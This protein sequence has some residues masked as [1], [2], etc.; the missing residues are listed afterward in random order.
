M[1]LIR[2]NPNETLYPTGSKSIIS[3]I[4]N[5]APPQIILWRVPYEDFNDGSKVIVAENEEALF[6]ENGIVEESF[7][8]GEYTLN[9]NNYPFLSRIRNLVSGG[10]SAYNC[11]IIYIN[12]IHQLDNRWGTDGPIQVI[13]KKYDIPINM[14]ARG[15]YSIQ[16]SNAKKFYMKIAGSTAS[17]LTTDDLCGNMRAPINQKIKSIIAKVVSGLESEIVGISSRLE[18]IAECARP[19]IESVFEEYGMRMVNFYIEAIEIVEDESYMILK[20][21][22]VSAAA[23]LVNATTAKA[24]VNILGDDYGRVKTADI[25]MAAAN[26]QGNSAV[27]D[28]LGIGAGMAMGGVMGASAMGVLSPLSSPTT[29]TPPEPRSDDDRFGTI[30][31]SV[32]IAPCGHKVLSDTKYCPECGKPVKIVC[33]RC[34]TGASPG[35]K[36]CKECGGGLL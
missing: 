16:I 9:T 6:Y 24:E 22:R 2:R 10:I 15:A 28:G 20:E 33:S 3:V 17:S 18:D 23:K 34:G 5:E 32:I 27:G 26:N 11:R 12:K 30:Q 1:S 36:F 25:M 29:H 21:A 31:E 7:T 13:D 8:G 4:K 14:M 19:H 35:D